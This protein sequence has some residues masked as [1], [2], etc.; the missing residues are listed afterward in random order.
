MNAF[1]RKAFLVGIVLLGAAG[2]FWSQRQSLTQIRADQ[3]LA[4]VELRQLDETRRTA[5]EQLASLERE[6]TMAQSNRDALLATIV[7]QQRQDAARV[8]EVRWTTPPEHWPEWTTDSPYVWLPKSTM[9][10][11]QAPVWDGTDGLR[12][13]IVAL[14]A[15]R[16]DEREAIDAT[17]RG[18]MA[19]WRSA[20]T[21]AATLST[22]HLSNLGGEGEAVTVQVQFQPELASRLRAELRVVLERQLGEQRA[23]LFEH[24]AGWRLDAE[25][26]PEKIP[27][28]GPKVYSVRR[29]GKQYRVATKGWGGSM[30]TIGDWR[31]T[32]PAHLHSIFAEA[33]KRQ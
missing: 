22:D 5:R 30:G 11:M 29:E 28:D 31:D 8:T 19:E 14:L 13:E 33:L 27:P 18:I 4:Q 26:G 24:F 32:I 21:A 9:K 20:E 6:F 7:R 25:F 16:P 2:C 15:I 3:V 23:G 17:T 12:D 1:G 10:R